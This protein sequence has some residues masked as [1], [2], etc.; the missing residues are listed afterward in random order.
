MRDREEAGREGRRVQEAVQQHRARVPAALGV[1][2]EGR[3]GLRQ[4]PR[5]Q[6]RGPGAQGLVEGLGGRRVAIG[7]RREVRVRQVAGDERE[8]PLRERLEEL[9]E[10]LPELGFLRR[11]RDLVRL[12]PRGLA[13]DH[14]PRRVERG[15]EEGQRDG[16]APAQRRGLEILERVELDDV[17]AAAAQR[18]HCVSCHVPRDLDVYRQRRLVAAVG[19]VA[20]EVQADLRGAAGHVRVE[21]EERDVRGLAVRRRE[22]HDVW[23]RGRDAIAHGRRRGAQRRRTVRAADERRVKAEVA[24][25]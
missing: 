4:R 24:V 20:V 3:R 16:L 21:E 25:R 6:R 18:I 15:V 11:H 17:E 23:P 14:E 13:E 19:A 5:V 9:E 12:P 7:P 22:E 1:V 8:H 2:R 10:R